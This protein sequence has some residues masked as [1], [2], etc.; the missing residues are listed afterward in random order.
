MPPA[1]G[2]QGASL[3]TVIGVPACTVTSACAK[4]VSQW[5]KYPRRRHKSFDLAQ[6]SMPPAGIF[7]PPRR[8][9]VGRVI[10]LV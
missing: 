7:T 5:L 2:R 6:D 3:W 4:L 8:V 9:A 1:F 10:L